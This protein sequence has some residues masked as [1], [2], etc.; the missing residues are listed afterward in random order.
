M[1]A[2]LYRPAHLLTHSPLVLVHG[3]APEGKDDP[4][5]RQAARLLARAGFAVAVPTIPG[6]T[7]L[8]LRPADAE[9]V[10]ET[11]RALPE[12]FDGRLVALVA[13]S[14]G[15][16]PALLA[17]ADPRVADQVALVVSL[18]GYASTVEVLRY[19]LTGA[20][21]YGGI[22]ERGEPNP[23]GAR[24]FLRANLDL[25]STLEDR[26]RL[27]AWLDAPGSGRP[28][29]LSPEGESVLRL[30]ENRDPDRLDPLVRALPR[31]L[32]ALLSALSPQ[33]ALPRLK[34]RLSLIH[35]RTDPVVPYT[36]SLRLA[37]AARRAGVPTR[38]TIMGAVE[39]V[40]ASADRRLSGR[41]L[42]ELTQLW[43]AAYEL[44]RSR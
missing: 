32:Q 5:L 7:G 23:D 8:R 10:V 31:L 28:R 16:A 21:R 6:L 36:E 41:R 1:S 15:A 29:E 38:L 20:Y 40:E 37:D 22:G 3:L 12:R 18:G 14:V 33:G 35:G 13:V 39:H 11:I 4:R 44:F 17:A 24:L 9:P 27:A 25:L 19:A 42:L 26:A 30:V 2:D 43:T 34:A